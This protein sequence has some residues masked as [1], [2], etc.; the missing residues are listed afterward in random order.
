MQLGTICESLEAKKDDSMDFDK[1]LSDFIATFSTGSFEFS[2][3]S[4]DPALERFINYIVEPFSRINTGSEDSLS[5]TQVLSK[6][7]IS[8]ITS[9]PTISTLVSKCFPLE[10]VLSTAC[11][12]IP[13][14][15]AITLLELCA[16]ATSGSYLTIIPNET[17]ST[18]FHNYIQLLQSTT[19]CSLT[20]CSLANLLRTH[21]IFLSFAR[22][23]AELKTFRDITTKSL[24]CDDH[25]CVIASLSALLA[26]FPR[27]IDPNT[28]RCAALHAISVAGD[29][30]LLLKTA[31]SLLTDISVVPTIS[32]DDF[33]S[34]VQCAVATTGMKAYLL[35]DGANR[36]LMNREQIFPLTGKQLNIDLILNLLV[37]T[38]N[39]YV[40][41]AV[42]SFIEQLYFQRDD[43]FDK[44]KDA[45]THAQKA[46]RLLSA[47]PNTIDIELLE[48]AATLLKYFANSKK[49][50]EQIKDVLE[51]GE[52]TLF[53]AFQRHIES[54][55]PYV[56]LLLF[57]FLSVTAKSIESWKKRIRLAIIDSQ[58]SA[59]L[60]HVVETS[61]DRRC[62]VDA[63]SAL[64]QI[65]QFEFGEQICDHSVIFDSIISGFMTVNLRSKE[66][67]K[68]Q[69]E[70]VESRVVAAHQSAEGM[71]AQI[72]CD[73][74][75]IQ[76]LYAKQEELEKENEELRNSCE[77]MNSDNESLKTTVDELKETKNSQNE[78]I[79]SL[80]DQLA[81]LNKENEAN[82]LTISQQE[83]KINE[84]T[85]QVDEQKAKEPQRLQMERDNAAYEVRVE[86]MNQQ[87]KS[88]QNNI[89]ELNNANDTLKSKAKE[90]K[91]QYTA[92][93]E[94][95]HNMDIEREKTQI[96][97]ADLKSQLDKSEE[98]RRNAHDKA[99]LIKEKLRETIKVLEDMQQREIETRRDIEDLERKNADLM[100]QLNTSI[101]EK[102]QF[103]LI[104][105]FVH[106]ITD[107]NPIPTD[108]LISMLDDSK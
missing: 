72:E 42:L 107:D 55:E 73:E 37:S 30:L 38:P 93:S 52:E 49:C 43:L 36:V 50:M 47:P 39:G 3:I 66:E 98:A 105:Q 41:H 17:I 65:S 4:N 71:K 104:A 56:S 21:P 77:Q 96:E 46:V 8:L 45:Q 23:S 28:I 86:Q 14:Q 6:F 40:A 1:T 32:E 99:H 106:R 57:L 81:K 48:G 95:F 102:K 78:Q 2:S 63:I 44:L 60:A 24:S 59:L 34:V 18:L 19:L 87:I 90:L 62:L 5:Y 12:E 22:A 54:S 7:V 13:T 31:I 16:F 61:T 58:F 83:A 88:L 75:E 74:L 10:K 82:K 9:S 33:N 76:S 29:N 89:Q 94:D 35:F 103:E 91:Q 108:Q 11:N 84:L 27:S 67:K 53:V 80:K 100:A 25:L 70:A 79:E 20:M 26:I 15:Y 64:S 69:E 51:Q 97:I 85:R 92:K 101:A 68:K